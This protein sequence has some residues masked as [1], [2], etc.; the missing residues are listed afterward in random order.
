MRTA[1]AVAPVVGDLAVTGDSVGGW[2]ADP[3]TV[4]VSA[5]D[6]RAVD[7]IEVSVDGAPWQATPGDS[8]EVD[9]DG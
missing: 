9:R 1:D 4:R 5:S 2:Y 8:A 6:D 7:R 3:A